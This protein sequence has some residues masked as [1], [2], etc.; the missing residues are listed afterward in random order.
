MS[1]VVF[2]QLCFVYARSKLTNRYRL[3]KHI[4]TLFLITHK[5][6][7]NISLQALVLIQQTVSSLVS[8]LP[9]TSTKSSSSAP[10]EKSK[11]KK[12][13]SAPAK[14]I[15]ARYYRTLYASLHDVRL[16]T[17]SKQAMY[18]NLLFKSIKGCVGIDMSTGTSGKGGEDTR[19]GTECA[20]ALVRRFVQVLVS[21][22]GG[23]AEFV[24]GGLFLLG[25]VGALLS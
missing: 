12:S 24:A 14:S 20:R 25:E 4:D 23:A 22:G 15:T 3:S 5:S 18:L 11:T 9:A 16:A 8:T 6:T 19:W 2:L 21:G 10:S 7:F 13:I 1:L 17:S